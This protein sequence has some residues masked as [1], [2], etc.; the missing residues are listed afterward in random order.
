[1]TINSLTT[2]NE[3]AETRSLDDLSESQLFK[4]VKIGNITLQHRIAM[5][6]LTRY[7]ASDDHVPQPSFQDYYSQ[8]AS[9]HG[10]LLIS[11]GTFISAQDGGYANAPG[12]YNDDQITAWR[13][14][15]DAVHAK[16]GYIFCQLWALGRTADPEVAERE[17]I[18]FRSSSDIPPDSFHPKPKPLST[19]EIHETAQRYA[20]AAKNAIDAGFDGVELHGANGY[21]IDQFIQ[22]KC[23]QRTDSYGGSIENRSRF[24]VEVTQAVCNAIGSERTGIRFSPW[25]TFNDMR[26]KDPISQFADVIKKLKPLNLAYLHLIESRIAGNLD[27]EASDTDK[28]DFAIKIWDRPLLIAGGFT[29]ERAQKLVDHD[30]PTKDIV[31]PFGRYFLSNPDLPFRIWRGL[32]LNK[33]NRATFYT[34]HT[35]EGYTDY[36]FS[37]EFL[38]HIKG[39]DAL[40]QVV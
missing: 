1:M 4:P 5:C 10:T 34:P 15:T 20:Q 25:S 28:L 3:K 22:D 7:R 37:Q 27:V 32:G 26:M 12:I 33:Y 38:D 21:L 14:V 35:T 18:V 36:P 39:G 13:S 17:G 8:R 24:A 29:P 23:N 16:G 31:V 6:P 2:R 9:V 19:G 40:G 11:E 30:W